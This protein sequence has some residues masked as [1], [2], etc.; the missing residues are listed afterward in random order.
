[1]SC[2]ILSDADLGYPT[3]FLSLPGDPITAQNPGNAPS[4]G[5]PDSPAENPTPQSG[6]FSRPSGFTPCASGRSSLAAVSDC[7]P[8][9]SFGSRGIL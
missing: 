4:P 1:M 6:E 9:P 3:P 7:D 8:L 2:L 5:A